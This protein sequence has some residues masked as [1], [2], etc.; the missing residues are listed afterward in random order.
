MRLNRLLKGWKGSEAAEKAGISKNTVRRVEAGLAV[1]DS[2]LAKL[3]RA[4]GAVPDG[5]TGFWMPSA[6]GNNFILQT[7]QD[8]TWLAMRILASG[9]SEVF[10]SD[11]ELTDKERNRLGRYGLASHFSIPLRVRRERSRFAP[12]L[13]EIYG[14]T[15][16]SKAADCERFIYVLSGRVIVQAGDEFFVVGEGEAAT[17]DTSEATS[18]APADPIDASHPAPRALVIVLPYPDANV[19]PVLGRRGVAEDIPL[20]KKRRTKSKGQRDPVKP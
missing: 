2:N 16:V 6:R 8:H 3:C 13:L 1:H 10:R 18:F 9:D 20:L 14:K 11:K 12:F 19:D 17:F 7:N 4:Y 15:D 5:P